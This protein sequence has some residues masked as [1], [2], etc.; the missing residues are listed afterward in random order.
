MFFGGIKMKKLVIIFI[1]CS[2]FSH[3]LSMDIE[4]ESQKSGCVSWIVS[5]LP[6]YSSCCDQRQSQLTIL[7]DEFLPDIT[8]FYD[9]SR[10]EFGKLVETARS[11]RSNL[12]NHI[13]ITNRSQKSSGELVKRIQEANNAS[14]TYKKKEIQKDRIKEVFVAG[15]LIVVSLAQGGY[16]LYN[17]I[18]SDDE[19]K[20]KAASGVTSGIAAVV[21]LFTAGRMLW[22][23]WRS[24]ELE[25][26]NYNR[27]VNKA[28]VDINEK[29][30]KNQDKF[31]ETLAAEYARPMRPLI[32]SKKRQ[33]IKPS[34]KNNSSPHVLQPVSVEGNAGEVTHVPSLMIKHED[35]DSPNKSRSDDN[36]QRIFSEVAPPQQQD[37]TFGNNR[38]SSAPNLTARRHDTGN[39][40]R[41]LLASTAAILNAERLKQKE[42]ESRPTSPELDEAEQGRSKRI[43]LII[44]GQTV[45][46]I[47]L[48]PSSQHTMQE[49]SD[50]SD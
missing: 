26:L 1:V 10:D 24:P 8:C 21:G 6:C 25:E 38:Y 37:D 30:L 20:N 27:A 9:K 23:A 19:P 3:A 44:D 4:D 43:S 35:S 13:A 15:G 39:I 31:I 42:K 33:V 32:H 2:Y 7:N 50:D 28:S 45:E 16:Q 41:R 18:A 22:H 34:S 46:A 5:W 11:A 49:T 47:L 36:I 40:D 17:I 12:D 14:Y 29:L 48:A